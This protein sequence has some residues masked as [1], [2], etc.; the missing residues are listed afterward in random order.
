MFSNCFNGILNDSF[1]GPSWF[2]Q[3]E[4]FSSGIGKNILFGIGNGAK[5][6]SQTRVIESPGGSCFPSNPTFLNPTLNIKWALFQFLSLFSVINDIT[7][8]INSLPTYTKLCWYETGPPT[9]T[10]P[11]PPPPPSADIFQSLLFQNI[12]LGTLSECQPV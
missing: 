12:V 9:P 1:F 11:P 4:N 3:I 2:G 10:P 5:F 7:N 6:R 8:L